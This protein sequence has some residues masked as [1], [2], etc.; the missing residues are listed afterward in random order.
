MNKFQKLGIRTEFAHTLR[1]YGILEP[2]PIQDR[3][4]PVVLAGRDVI[5][6]AQTGTGKTLAFLLPIL[7]KVDPQSKHIQALIVS[8]TRELALQTTAEAKKLVANA[9]DIHVLPVYGG[10]D[11]EQ[12][13]KQLEGSVHVVIGTPGRLLDHL[14]RG[15]IA[16][17]DVNMLVLDEADQMLHMGFLDEVEQLLDATPAT[18]QTM[19]FSATMPEP[20]RELATKFMRSPEEIQVRGKTV[21][22]KDIKQVV[23]ETTDRAKQSTLFSLLDMHRPYLAIIFCRTIR[24]ASKLNAALQERGY[25]SDELHGDLS[26]AKREQVMQRFRDADIQLLVATDVA[27]RGLDVD[28]VTHVFNYDIPH[29]VESYIHRIGRTGRAG[30]KGLAITLV[31]QKDQMFLQMIEA[32]IGQSIKRKM[33]DGTQEI[34]DKQARTSSRPRGSDSKSSRQKGQLSQPSR[35]RKNVAG[36][37]SQKPKQGS[38]RRPGRSS[39]PKRGR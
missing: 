27:A 14:R 20:I 38:A 21:T 8:P 32:G 18:R 9:A 26:Q 5:A 31:A 3:T 22:V 39:S 36:K 19:L 25:H 13:M 28:G 1:D 23:V 11:V 33:L 16:L 30:G 6:E 10:H 12:Q 34:G 15:T 17:S 24:R 35:Q 2:T 7:E 29:D 37:P 4:I